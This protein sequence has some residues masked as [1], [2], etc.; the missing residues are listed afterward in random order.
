MAQESNVCYKKWPNMICLE[1][2]VSVLLSNALFITHLYLGLMNELHKCLSCSELKTHTALP[3]T[4]FTSFSLI[5]S[6]WLSIIRFARLVRCLLFA[7][8]NHDINLELRKSASRAK[9]WK[10]PWAV[11]RAWLFID[12]CMN[13]IDLEKTQLHFGVSVLVNS[14]RLC[15]IHLETL[16][17]QFTNQRFYNY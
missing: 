15:L 4:L 6:V 13:Y 1:M 16:K 9:A 7:M 5:R 8:L 3:P 10:M 11:H 2:L 12:C 14:L 17:G